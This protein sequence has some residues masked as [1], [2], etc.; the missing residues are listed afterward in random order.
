MKMASSAFIPFWV[1][2]IL[3]ATVLVVGCGGSVP[4]LPKLGS[5]SAILAFGNSLTFGTGA[6]ENQSY[7]VVLSRLIHRTVIREGVPGELSSEGLK[8]LPRILDKYHPQLLILCHGGNDLLRK[9]D[10]ARTADHIRSMIRLALARQIPVVLVGVPKPSITVGIPSFYQKLA[11]E[12]ELPI[13]EGVV[14]DILLNPRLKSDQIH[15]N[16]EGYQLMAER[17]Y[18][19]L[20][21]SGAV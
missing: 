3:I 21:K 2:S 7:P 17:L 15:P 18:E 11:E 4:Q 6:K 12:F 9:M 13:E 19:L 16:A 10:T 1:S 8:R 5:E 20:K 14:R